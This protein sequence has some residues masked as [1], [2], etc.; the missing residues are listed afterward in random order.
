MDESNFDCEHLNRM[1][2]LEPRLITVQSY[3][4]TTAGGVVFCSTISKMRKI[5]RLIHMAN[6]GLSSGYHS[7]SGM[8]LVILFVFG[9]MDLV[10]E[11]AV[12]DQRLR[13]PPND[14]EES[15]N[16]LAHNHPC[17]GFEPA[18]PRRVIRGAVASV[19]LTLSPLSH[20]QRR[21]NH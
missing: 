6:H 2:K 19:F 10:V 14:G 9:S 16:P 1:K 17:M 5:R 4:R 20:T 15:S 7:K 13:E 12:T 3:V 18:N 11:E 8:G 21:I